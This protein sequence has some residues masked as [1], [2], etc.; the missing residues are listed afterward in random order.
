ME[1]IK[2]IKK[3]R[4]ELKKYRSDKKIGF[5]PTM[6][7]FHEGH[8]SLMDKAKTESDIVVVSLYVNPTQFGP[9]EDLAVYPRDFERDEKLAKEHG[10]DIIFYPNNSEMYPDGYKTFVFTEDL[11]KKLCGKSRNN[12]FKG[13]TTIVAKLFNI[14]QPDIAVFGQKDHQ[15]AIIL[16]KMITDLNIPVKMIISPIIRE[17]DGLAMSSRNKFLS[18]EARQEAK[19]L[20]QAL[21]E[22]KIAVEN[23]ELDS[24]I[25]KMQITKKINQSTLANIEYV[26]IINNNDLNSVTG[27]NSGTFAAV[28]VFYGKTRL[29]DNIILKN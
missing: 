29:I 4:A 16:Q 1:V 26:E 27:I 24:N 7:Y 17:T 20:F 23:G 9:N 21:N 12:H 3:L 15:Q 2:S 13:V 19:I 18:K 8:L 6:G 5:V 11:S 10:V 22:A 14:I 25:L 28:A